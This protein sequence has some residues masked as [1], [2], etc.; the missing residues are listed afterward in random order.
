MRTTQ[1]KDIDCVFA[2]FSDANSNKSKR[3]SQSDRE[4]RLGA[5]VF[6]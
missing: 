5:N 2:K 3:E 6:L 1:R 4:V